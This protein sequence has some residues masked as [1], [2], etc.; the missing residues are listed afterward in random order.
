MYFYLHVIRQYLLP[1]NNFLGVSLFC[2]VLKYYLMH[3]TPLI[4]LALHYK[5]PIKQHEGIKIKRNV[6]NFAKSLPH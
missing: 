4:V 1:D 5:N 6:V 2:K 3:L